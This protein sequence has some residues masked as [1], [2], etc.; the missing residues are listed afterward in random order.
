MRKTGV[1]K[2]FELYDSNFFETEGYILTLPF[3]QEE[4]EN[5]EYCKGQI[6]NALEFMRKKCV[7][8]EYS[9]YSFM[10]FG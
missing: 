6:T 1:Y 2:K 7:D 9:N 5:F 4:I 3:L 10:E 8:F